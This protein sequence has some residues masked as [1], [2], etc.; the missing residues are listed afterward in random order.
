MCNKVK[1]NIEWRAKIPVPFYSIWFKWTIHNLRF[2]RFQSIDWHFSFDVQLVSTY[3]H[4]L[5]LFVQ[6]IFSILPY[7]VRFSAVHILI[8]FS[9][10]LTYRFTS[11]FK[12][13]YKIPRGSVIDLSRDRGHV[14]RTISKILLQ[15]KNVTFRIVSN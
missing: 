7:L 4:Y 15:N 9:Q 13:E 6:H 5:P 11:Q 12:D 8:L 14:L 10:K 2:F 3:G 1:E